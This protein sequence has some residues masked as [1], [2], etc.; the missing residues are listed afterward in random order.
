MEFLNFDEL[1]YRREYVD[2]RIKIHHL[3]HMTTKNDRW[4]ALRYYLDKY[5]KHLSK[6]TFKNL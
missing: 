2:N 6:I 1:K 5:L 3:L 4:I